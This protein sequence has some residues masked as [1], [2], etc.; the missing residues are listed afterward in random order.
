ML[1]LCMIL[2]A[3]RNYSSQL[4]KDTVWNKKNKIHFFDRTQKSRSIETTRFPAE[5]K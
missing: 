4:A 5:Q 1:I 2:D 3:T